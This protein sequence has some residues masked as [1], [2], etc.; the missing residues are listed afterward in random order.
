MGSTG[1]SFIVDIQGM[2][3]AFFEVTGLPADTSVVNSTTIRNIG[4][5]K[6]AGTPNAIDVTFR[7]GITNSREFCQWCAQALAGGQQRLAG[8]ITL[9]NEM[10]KPARVWKFSQGLPTK[11]TAP[12]LNS[13][14]NE[15]AIEELNLTV[16]GL[17]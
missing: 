8:T 7:R 11:I 6:E 17:E 1:L 16:E 2:K 10:G 12:A 14:G 9:L 5:R 3:A 4:I 15:V 13:T